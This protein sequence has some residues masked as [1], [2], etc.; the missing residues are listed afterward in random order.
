MLDSINHPKFDCYRAYIELARRN[1]KTWEF[2]EDLNRTSGELDRWFLDQE[3]T[4]FWPRLGATA[5]MRVAQ[6]LAIVAAKHSAEDM[7]VA[8]TRPLVIVGVE[9]SEQNILRCTVNSRH[10]CFKLPAAV[11]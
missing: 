3:E 11:C 6:W 4:H 7:S 10:S 1:G 2:L 5:E 9:E 8:A